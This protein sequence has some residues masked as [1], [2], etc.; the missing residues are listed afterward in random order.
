MF[1]LTLDERDRRWKKVRDAME[2]QG[3]ECLVI[4]GSY[5]RFRH[6]GANL[7][8]LSNISVEGYLVFPLKEDPTLV[9]FFA[10]PD[11]TAWV[12]DGRT[13]HPNYSKIVSDRIRE[14]RL[15]K[16]SIG[17]VGLS[18]Y[19]GEM[20]FPHTTYVAITSN[21][22]R[23]EFQDATEIMTGVRIIK[24][25]AEI[26][27]L[28]LG[29]EI[30]ERIIQVIGNTAKA[31]VPDSEVR[32]GVMDTLFREGCEPGS[33]FLYH[34][35]KEI[36]HPGQGG[37]Y[38]PPQLNI[39]KAG[40]I[41]LTEFDAIYSGYVAQYNQPFSIGEPDQEWKEIFT[42]AANAFNLGLNTLKPGITT[43]ELYQ[44]ILSP[45][46]E[47]GYTS[48]NPAF[49][50]LG[51]GLEDPVSIFP[52]Q[53]GYRPDTSLRMQP[54]MVVEFE[55]HVVRPD[56]KKGASLG[57]PVLVTE[58]GCRLLSKNWKPEVRITG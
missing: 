1:N 17:V 19:D 45:I 46:K 30:G 50:G 38:K 29:C 48:T 44:A 56:F 51:L 41:I 2:K 7:K 54:G 32:A 27:C 53:T 22:P 31:G 15:E 42:V 58:T 21:F 13:G 39:L 4:W 11:P 12:A 47:A 36:L 5:G 9:M 40:D 43:G 37:Q 52:A 35:G 14:L 16:G 6:F 23:A 18:G 3:F 26:K 49:H 55:P 24:S 33:M 57:S 20:G 8:Y 10:R 28:E 25:P 34:S